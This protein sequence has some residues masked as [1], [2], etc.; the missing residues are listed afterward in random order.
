[1]DQ[2]FC[3]WETG[4]WVNPLTFS[5][6]SWAIFWDL[7]GSTV[8]LGVLLTWGGVGLQQC[9][10]T[11]SSVHMKANNQGSPA[12]HCLTV[13]LAVLV[14][15]PVSGFNVVADQCMWTFGHLQS[16]PTPDGWKSTRRVEISFWLHCQLLFRD[17]KKNPSATC[18]SLMQMRKIHLNHSSTYPRIKVVIHMLTRCVLSPPLLYF[19]AT[20]LMSSSL[21]ACIT[22]SIS[23][24]ISSN[25]SLSKSINSTL[26]LRSR[27]QPLR[28]RTSTASYRLRQ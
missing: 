26:S 19:S 8:Q 18:V 4:V 2:K 13:R 15:S 27:C 20:A 11:V 25:S 23:S 17:F 3:E 24:L 22:V 14:F 6:C 10:Y 12:A 9:L 1:M 21:P 5:L 7:A 28:A 16:F